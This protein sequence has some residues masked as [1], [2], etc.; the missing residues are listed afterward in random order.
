MKVGTLLLIMA[1]VINLLKVKGLITI[2][3]D[4]G[5]FGNI[6]ND[7]ALSGAVEV[8]LKEHGVNT[9]DKVDQILQILPLVAG[10][11]K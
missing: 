2:T 9:P 6:Q 4:F 7:L 5:D 1:D 10:M 8:I 3:G 11:I